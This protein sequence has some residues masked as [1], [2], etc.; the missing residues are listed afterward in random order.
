MIQNLAYVLM[1]LLNILPTSPFI[2]MTN[3]LEKYEFLGMLNWFIPFDI[4]AS[5]LAMWCLC[6][7]SYIGYEVVKGRIM[8]M[9]NKWLT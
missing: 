5:F 3:T 7:V 1:S 4:C 9:V 8:A 6:M 2:S